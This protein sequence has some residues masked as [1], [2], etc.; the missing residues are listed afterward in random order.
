MH[1]MKSGKE[2]NGS[3][4]QR[5]ILLVRHRLAPLVAAIL[6]RNFKGDVGEPAI[7]L[8]AV[9]VL[10]VRRNGD[11]RAGDEAHRGLAFFLIPAL[12]RGADEHL[13]AALRGVMDVPP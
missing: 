7:L 4:R 5:V 13:P 6:A 10:H 3:V 9:P 12:A 11:D 8:R 1:A 2:R